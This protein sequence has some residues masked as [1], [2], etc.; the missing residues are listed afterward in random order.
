MTNLKTAELKPF[1]PPS[2]ILSKIK[3]KFTLNL[4][5][6]TTSGGLQKKKSVVIILLLPPEIMSQRRYMSPSNP[7]N[8]NM[9]HD[10]IRDMTHDIMSQR[11]WMSPSNPN[12]KH[13]H[14]GLIHHFTF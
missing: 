8:R 7:N 13:D 10:I 4:K 12:N 9:T 14:V 3:S 5:S 11:R 2:P 6:A 1:P